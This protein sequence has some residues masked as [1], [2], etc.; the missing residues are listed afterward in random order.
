MSTSH[1]YDTIRA[2]LQ[3]HLPTIIASQLESLSLAIIGAVQSQSSQLAK[4]ARA[5]PIDTT[6]VA[7]EQR[8]RRL[9]DNERLTQTDQYHPVVQQALHGLAQQRVQLLIDRVLLRDQHN[10]LV[11]SVAFRRRSIPLVWRALPHR[12]SSNLTEQQDLIQTAAQL[13][14]SEVRISV[15][16]DSEF[17]S[18]A[19][20]AWLRAQGYDPMLGISGRLWVYDTD[21]PTAVGQPL[22]DRVTPLP[23]QTERGRKRKHRTSPVTYL[24]H[25]YVVQEVRNGPVNI[26]A[27]WERD[28]DGK[29]VLHAVMTNLPATARTKAY[30]K[31]R[32]WIE[33][34]FRDWQSGGFHLEA[35]GIP[36]TDR[37]VRLL[38]VLAIA[39]LWLVSLGRWVVKRGYRRLIDD[40]GS[41][42]WHF[43]L[44]QLGVGWMERLRSFP[45]PP[46]IILYLYV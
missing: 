43:S 4:I 17:R 14:P 10:I 46:P 38:I 2:A 42:D 28:A 22:A 29:V 45:Q 36:D 21:D 37:V 31:R 40:G 8:V 16:G 11:V 39:Y 44:F 34:V 13:L 6:E 41:R 3:R 30:G 20:F 25:V 24:A 19:L 12:G 32:M 35:C 15:H 5:L 27:W 7:K 1:V 18:Q 26:I 9:L 33:T 23:P